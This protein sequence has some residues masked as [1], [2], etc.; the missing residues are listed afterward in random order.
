MTFLEAFGVLGAVS[1]AFYGVLCLLGR[2][3]CWW[4]DRVR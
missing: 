3:W 1:L 4:M 2:L